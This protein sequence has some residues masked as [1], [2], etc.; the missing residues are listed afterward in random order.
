[1]AFMVSQ[2]T[3]TWRL[4]QSPPSRGAE[5]MAI[6]EAIL[7][8]VSAGVSP[9]TLRLYAWLPPCLSLGY[10]QTVTD[11]DQQLLHENQWDIVRRPTGGRAILHTDELTYSVIASDVNALVAGGVLEGYRRLSQGL[12]AALALLN[13]EVEIQPEIPIPEHQRENPTCFQVPSAYEILVRG[14]KLIGSAQMRRRGGVLQHGTLPISGDISR[15]CEVL[16]FNNERA[17]QRAAQQ[18]LE[19]ATTIEALV[20]TTVSW[21]QVA[22]TVVEGFTQALG[23]SFA[24]GSP[25]DL[26]I[27][28]A[29]E[30]VQN[31]YDNP[32]WTE[33]I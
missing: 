31:R 24:P 21:Q 14:K 18:L 22:Q 27:T 29:K 16:F 12:V 7:Q 3:E 4:I 10:S 9:P 32:D 25:T 6:D 33:R 5:N 28:R 1:M 17:R 11:V 23:L 20:G 8:G 15:I 13:L 19:R 30:L 2:I 26:E